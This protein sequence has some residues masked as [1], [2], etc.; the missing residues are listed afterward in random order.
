MRYSRPEALLNAASLAKIIDNSDVSIIDGSFYLPQAN[1]D[2]RKDFQEAH[3]PGSIFFDI[4][5]VADVSTSLPHMLPDPEIFA[6]KVGKLGISNQDHVVC[7]DTNNGAMAA[8]RVFWTFKVFGH[9]KLSVLEGGLN[10]W[11]QQGYEVSN[12]QTPIA[13]TN[14]ISRTANQA[15]VRSI[16]QV[17]ENLG[18]NAEQFVDVRSSGKFLATEPEPR[19]DLR[20]GHIPGSLNLPFQKIF[21]PKNGGR[22][23]T[24]EKLIHLIS[25][26]GIDPSKPIIASC[27]S[28]VTAAVLYFS[29]YLLGYDTAAIYD[30]SWTEWAS[31]D[32]TPIISNSD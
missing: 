1:R 23:L 5:E 28:G 14:Y 4:N 10:S 8:M 13:P 16:E 30:G 22:I 6:E 12:K 25:N 20:S 19:P 32:D 11:R 9:E 15:L 29:L 26:A 24:A 18:T 21:D 2:V 17:I 27:G 7:Y 31:R 3:I